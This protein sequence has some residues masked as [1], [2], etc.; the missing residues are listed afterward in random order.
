MRPSRWSLLCASLVLAAS[1]ALAADDEVIYFTN[2]TSMTAV[3]HRI[4][5]GMIHVELSPNAIVAFPAE[6]VERIVRGGQQIDPWSS[7]GTVRPRKDGPMKAASRA[8]GASYASRPAAA[9]I[10]DPNRETGDPN[11]APEFGVLD[12]GVPFMRPMAGSSNPR[13]RELKALG[14]QSLL[15][16]RTQGGNA[17]VDGRGAPRIIA[18]GETGTMPPVERLPTSFGQRGN[19]SSGKKTGDQPEGDAEAE[20]DG[21]D[22]QD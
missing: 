11:A 18:P 2:G 9:L 1:V 7:T 5:D 17:A 19:A 6:M 10:E 21:A 13:K 15:R 14:H 22:P 3:S 20:A 16:Q 8:D 4:E 12:S